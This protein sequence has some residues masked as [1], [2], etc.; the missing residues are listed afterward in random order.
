MDTTREPVLTPRLLT[1]LGL[2]ALGLGL[3]FFFGKVLPAPVAAGIAGGIAIAVIGF[4]L[5]VVESLR[6]PPERAAGTESPGEDSRST[7]MGGR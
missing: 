1:G 5:T 7:D 4:V 2:I 6:E 3:M